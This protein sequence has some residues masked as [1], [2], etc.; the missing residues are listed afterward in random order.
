MNEIVILK[1]F[2]SVSWWVLLHG[3]GMLNDFL[4]LILFLFNF[5]GI[6]IY[7]SAALA[8]SESSLIVQRRDL[9][10]LLASRL[11][12]AVFNLL[13]R[14]TEVRHNAEGWRHHGG[15]R[16]TM[17]TVHHATCDGLLLLVV[18]LFFRRF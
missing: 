14:E 17:R 18:G 6:L 11:V 2:L 13:M 15:W 8:V 3:V 1:Q 4:D 12:R 7:S 9:L 10:L 5:G 16:D